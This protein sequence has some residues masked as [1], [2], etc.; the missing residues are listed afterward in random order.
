MDF[1][2]YKPVAEDQHS[3]TIEHPSGKRLFIDKMKLSLPAHKAIRCLY[4]GGD[5]SGDGDASSVEGG[6]MPASSEAEPPG[7]PVDN[8]G[9]EVPANTD[10]ITDFSR[11]ASDKRL[12]IR[13]K[14]QAKID[15]VP[16]GAPPVNPEYQV[17][18]ATTDPAVALSAAQRLEDTSRGRS[19]NSVD[20]LVQDKMDYGQL[21]EQEVGQQQEFEKGQAAAT[22][23]IADVQQGAANKEMMIPSAYATM[24]KYNEQ[25]QALEKAYADKTIDPQRLLH[26]MGTGSKIATGIGM[27]LSGMG[28]ATT[29]QPNLAIKVLDDAINRDI[30]SQ[31]EDKSQAMNLWKMNREKL[32]SEQAANLA[33]RNQILSS[34]TAQLQSA[35]T[36]AQNP[37]NKLRAQQAINQIKQEM[38]GNNL[39]RSLLTQPAQGAHPGQASNLS[40]ADP[41]MLVNDMIKE[42]GEKAKAMEEIR[43]RQN[44]NRN[45]QAMADA[46]EE[47]VKQT[48]GPYGAT[49]SMLP[50]GLGFEPPAI[51]KLNNL[52]QP[53]LDTI[54]E[55]VRQSGKDSFMKNV[56]PRG[57]DSAAQIEGRRQ[58][59]KEWLKAQAASPVS[60]G[61][62]IDLD[63][64][65][66]TALP[67]Q[68]AKAPNQA[69][70]AQT[71]QY[72]DWAKQ[73]PN[74]PKA[75]AVLKKLGVK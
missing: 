71:K 44:I 46:F 10:P 40:G 34:A 60:K 8:V 24:A 62:Y 50:N 15:A 73:N 55:S 16:Q 13:P 32:G 42:P 29:G 51:T 63:R 45:G 17:G 59:L 35:Q 58:A 21:L 53:M 14:L 5:A 69:L 75:Q 65:Q 28:A 48:S 56:V 4:E 9:D 67:S 43:K 52:A 18:T 68:G 57:T 61:N 20:P 37:A 22:K 47:A 30:D 38:I 70:S 27:I 2:H 64:F 72:Y 36:L 26:K 66:G 39:R 74:N 31:K 54:D 1:K 7:D 11:A 41:A 25:D 23:N 33:T 49:T 3:Y 19:P 12:G 6:R